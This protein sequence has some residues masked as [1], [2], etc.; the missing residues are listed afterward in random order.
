MDKGEGKRKSTVRRPMLYI[1]FAFAAPAAAGYYCGSKVLILTAVTCMLTLAFSSRERRL[2]AALC[3]VL[4]SYLAGTVNFMLYDA[5]K[6]VPV[7]QEGEVYEMTGKIVQINQKEMSDGTYRNQYRIRIFRSG[8]NIMLFRD[9]LAVRYAEN[10]DDGMVPGDIVNIE[11]TAERPSPRRNPGCFD[12]SLYLRSAGINDVIKADSVEL[13]DGKGMHTVIGRLYVF[14]ETF[15]S[16]LEQEAGHDASSMM[17]AILFGEKDELNE[18]VLEEFQKNGTAHVLAVSGLHIGIIYA[19]LSKLWRWKKGRLHFAATMMFFCGY[20]VLASFSPSVTRAVIM[21]GLHQFALLTN[22]RYDLYSAAF[23]TAAV[24]MLRNPMCIFNTGFQMSFLAVLTMMMVMPAA[25]KIYKGIFAASISVQAGLMPYVAYVF[26]YLSPGAVFVNAPVIFLTGIIVPM[27]LCAMVFSV[28][29]GGLFS[30]ASAAAAGLCRLMIILNHVSVA[31]G[32]T[33]FEVTSPGKGVLVFYYLSLLAFLSE[34]GRLVIKRRGGKKMMPLMLSAVMVLSFSFGKICSSGFEKADLTFVDVG[35]GDCIHFRTEDGGN[36]FVDGGGSIN[37][38]VGKKVLK[39]YLLK[40][41]VKKLDG[42]FVTHLHTDHYKGI[43]ELCREGMVKRLYLYEGNRPREEE[44]L[45]ETGLEPE[46]LTYLYK[47]QTVQ[48]SADTS[49]KVLWPERR[50]E[51]AYEKMLQ[52]EE[53]ENQS[54]LIMKICM[55]HASVTATGDVDA[56]CLQ[57]IGDLWRGGIRCDILKVAHHGSRY[58]YSEEFTKQAAPSYA[59]FQVGKNNF[60]HP[61]NGVVENYRQNGIMIYRNDEDGAV[62]F[63]FS[64][65]GKAEVMTMLG[66]R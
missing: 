32:V 48:L 39:P 26:N 5:V 41:G 20:A 66:R 14:R 56:E 33:V 1:A 34:E 31:D 43:A 54:S 64:E 55:R 53:D 6:G 12:Y 46:A 63:D 22:R 65:D 10:A 60:G 19:V 25:A 62:A 50:T 11:G 49:V 15:L 52:R 27:G 18:D 24:M 17:G 44:I 40:N 9:V 57:E 47:G 7:L 2:P 45:R 42:A 3:I 36:Y 37:Y 58:S 16:K 61:D 30:A 35:Q 59:V 38:N 23:C 13:V 28:L 8:G 51:S 4:V 29:P 21:I